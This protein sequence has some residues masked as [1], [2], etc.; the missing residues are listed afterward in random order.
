LRKPLH[1]D[2]QLLLAALRRHQT[3]E[4]RFEAIINNPTLSVEV[5]LEVVSFLDPQKRRVALAG[6]DRAQLL[7]TW[8][9]T[10]SPRERAL[11]AFNPHTPAAVLRQ[12]AADPDPDVRK[13]VCFNPNAAPDVLAS[14]LLDPSPEVQD[15]VTCAFDTDAGHHLRRGVWTAAQIRTD[16]GRCHGDGRERSSGAHDSDGWQEEEAR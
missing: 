11:V 8:A 7:T 16:V 9:A 4:E 3:D 1:A 5:L 12:L 13:Q 14:L 2:V 15:A 10:G 6:S